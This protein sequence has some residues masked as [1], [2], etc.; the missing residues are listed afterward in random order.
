MLSYQRIKYLPSFCSNAIVNVS[1]TSPINAATAVKLNSK[2]TATFNVGMNSATINATTFTLMQGTNSVQGNVTY[3][4]GTAVFTPTAYLA[5]NTSY[6][7]T[8]TTGAKDLAGNTLANAYVWS[9][10]TETV[11]PTI[12]TV[13]ATF[14]LNLA[15]DFSTN[16]AITASFSDEMDPLTITSQ[17]FTVKAGTTPVTGS[18]F[19]FASNKLAYFQPS[20]A[21]LP[22]TFYTAT[23]TT[24]AKNLFGNALTSDYVWNFTTETPAWS[25]SISGTTNQ[26]N[27]VVFG[28]G[29][30]V[31]VGSLG[32]ILTSPDGINWTTQTSG[33]SS[34]LNGITYA[35]SQYLAVGSSG[36]VLT[37]PNGTSWTSRTSATGNQLTSV[38]YGSGN[39]VAVGNTGTIQTSP[40]GIAWTLRT[41]GVTKDI[42]GV[43]YGGNQFVAV[44]AY[45]TGIAD[46]TTIL[47]SPDGINWT[48]RSASLYATF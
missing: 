16:I 28:G 1:S 47:T 2:L 33:V 3:T 29:Q 40:D 25:N 22:S 45:L 43:T 23:I 38:Y 32:T 26:L 41:S 12:P 7:A 30:F 11:A 15:T 5:S 37:S 44:G 31:A 17:T 14:P 20:S 18:V 6:T 19:Y 21:L 27:A 4:S 10:T 35:G 46:S 13:T 48:A 8:I 34:D 9:F 36:T 39:Y 24:G 42:Y